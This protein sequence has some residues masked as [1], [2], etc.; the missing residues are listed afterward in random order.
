M[1]IF[2][3]V[4]LVESGLN[5]PMGTFEYIR[6]YMNVLRLAECLLKQL[7]FPVIPRLVPPEVSTVI[8]DVLIDI[9]LHQGPVLHLVSDGAQPILFG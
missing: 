3:S 6:Q 4:Q 9:Q 1:E 2:M 8:L 5:G 7:N